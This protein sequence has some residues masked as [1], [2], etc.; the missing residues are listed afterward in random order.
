MDLAS[1]GRSHLRAALTGALQSLPVAE[2]LDEN[3]APVRVYYKPLTGEE[4]IQIESMQSESTVKG[5]CMAIKVR[6]LKADGSKAFGGVPIESLISD[7]NYPILLRIFL[8]MKA[9]AP[10]QEALEKE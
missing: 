9:S 5:V 2:W 3:K 7:Y 10:D 8:G 6:A 4:Q 1:I